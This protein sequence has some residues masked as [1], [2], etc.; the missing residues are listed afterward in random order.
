MVY[1]RFD[2]SSEGCLVMSYFS[3]RTA[4]EIGNGVEGAKMKAFKEGLTLRREGKDVKVTRVD[5]FEITSE[6]DAL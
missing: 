5:M 4:T 2:V 3:H 1:T 6:L